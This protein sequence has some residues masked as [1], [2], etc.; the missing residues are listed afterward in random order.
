MN[1]KQLDIMLVMINHSLN[2]DFF[3]KPL[4]Y[5]SLSMEKIF[6]FSTRRK[7]TFLWIHE[8]L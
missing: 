6:S 1:V 2:I 7:D 5:I 3:I 8:H 4:L